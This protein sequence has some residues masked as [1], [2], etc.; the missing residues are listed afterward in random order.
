MRCGCVVPTGNWAEPPTSPNP[1]RT[2]ACCA[3]TQE[4]EGAGEGGRGEGG[5]ALEQGLGD[6]GDH[7]GMKRSGAFQAEK[8]RVCVCVPVCACVCVESAGLQEL[9]E[10]ALSG[11]G[12]ERCAG[13]VGVGKWPRM[14][15]PGAWILSSGQQKVK[16][17]SKAGVAPSHLR[18]REI[19]MAEVP[20]HTD[21][22][23][24]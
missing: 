16:E 21:F 23:V 4:G 14:P 6:C 5:E 12:C 2:V 13:G 17:G 1:D 11:G 19:P 9:L 10:G 24:S 7:P 8:T 22:L 3:R 18:E 15:D 20:Q